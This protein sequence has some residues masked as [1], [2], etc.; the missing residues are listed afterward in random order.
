MSIFFERRLLSYLVTVKN[1]FEMNSQLYQLCALEA[2]L[3]VFIF[4][5]I[6]YIPECFQGIQ[7]EWHMF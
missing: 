1:T 3:N 4:V 5:K 6:P 7:R 2:F